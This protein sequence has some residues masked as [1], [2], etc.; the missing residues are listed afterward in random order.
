MGTTLYE[1]VHGVDNLSDYSRK[2][3]LKIQKNLFEKYRRNNFVLSNAIEGEPS[4]EDCFWQLSKVNKGIR[5]ILPRKKDEEQNRKA[6]K[7]G[8]LIPDLPYLEKDGIFHLD[9]YITSLGTNTASAILAGGVIYGLSQLFGKS[10]QL[11]T[12]ICLSG[13]FG[14]INFSRQEPIIDNLRGNCKL[15]TRLAF[16]EI[17]YLS[18]KIREFYHSSSK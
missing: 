9:N 12:V 14:L 1:L 17:R 10:I 3:I 6:R 11:E 7:M 5:V 15:K 4:L 2:Q 13:L 18:D 8:E 16:S